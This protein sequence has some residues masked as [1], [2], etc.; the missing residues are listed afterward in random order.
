MY[1]NTI[2]RN[3]DR[4]SPSF[5]PRLYI[6]GEFRDYVFSIA[7]ELFLLYSTQSLTKLSAL[8]QNMEVSAAELGE[9]LREQLLP[10]R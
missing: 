8:V 6:R 2:S 1:S 3:L 4:Y 5:I 9:V 7:N 10:H